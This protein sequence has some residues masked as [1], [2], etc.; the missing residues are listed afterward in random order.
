MPRPTTT[1][2]PLAVIARVAKIS[3]IPAAHKRDSSHAAGL[4][5]LYEPL[6]CLL[7]RAIYSPSERNTD[8]PAT[9]LG[10]IKFGIQNSENW[11]EFGHRA[12]RLFLRR[13]TQTCWAIPQQENK[14]EALGRRV[15]NRLGDIG[16]ALV[17]GYLRSVAAV[18]LA[19]SIQPT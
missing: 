16:A 6:S 14:F 5:I 3:S 2:A 19:P 13:I 10:E 4:R 18:S 8:G 12:S 7:G 1:T 15:K 11:V 17:A 9:D